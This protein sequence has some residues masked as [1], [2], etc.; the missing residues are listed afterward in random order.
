M[1]LYCRVKE[2]QRTSSKA[3]KKLNY[4]TPKQ[5]HHPLLSSLTFPVQFYLRLNN[6]QL[7]FK[8]RPIQD[9]WKENLVG[10]KQVTK[11]GNSYQRVG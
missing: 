10:N 7:I 5:H 2:K 9:E 6:S 11:T 8:P 4:Y 1:L 3:K